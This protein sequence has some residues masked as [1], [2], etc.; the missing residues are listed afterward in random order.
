MLYCPDLVFTLVSLTRCDMARYMVQLKDRACVINDKAGHTISRIP[1]TNG[2]YQV[3]R[4]A[5]PATAAYSGIK[6]FSLDEVHHKMGHISH[7]A[8]K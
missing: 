8:V 5:V 3:D 4:D 1:L 7:K 2:L 6:V